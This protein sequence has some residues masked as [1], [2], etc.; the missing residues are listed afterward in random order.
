MILLHFPSSGLSA[1]KGCFNPNGCV[2]GTTLDETTGDFRSRTLFKLSPPPHR[3]HSISGKNLAFP[4]EIPAKK[5]YQ[6]DGSLDK[7]K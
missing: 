4:F 3:Q 6:V 2:Y 5:E 7:E 1:P